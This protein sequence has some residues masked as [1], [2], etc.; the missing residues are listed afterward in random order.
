MTNVGKEKL[1]FSLPRTVCMTGV[2]IGNA[3]SLLRGKNTSPGSHHNLIPISLVARHH[4]DKPGG[5]LIEMSTL[6]IGFR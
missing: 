3:W 4:G 2:S 6:L 5:R 1:I